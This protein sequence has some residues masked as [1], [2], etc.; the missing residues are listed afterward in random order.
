MHRIR[1]QF[2]R[3]LSPFGGGI[4]DVSLAPED[5]AAI[6]F[7]TKNAAP[8]LPLLEELRNLGHCFTF[9]YTINNYP[10]F[11]EP[12]VPQWGHT[13]EIVEQLSRRFSPAV[14]RWRYDTIVLSESLNWKWHK[15]NFRALC[16]SLAP[17]AT[18]CIFSFCDYYRKTVR[19]MERG[20][21][22]YWRPSEV[23][24][25]EMAEEMAD[26]AKQWG[27]SVSS[28]AHDFLVSE[29]V[30]KA[31]CIDPAVLSQIVNSPERLAAVK[32]LKKAPTRKDCGCAASR[33]VGAYDTCL[34]GCVY[35]YAN[36]DP[37]SARRNVALVTED[38]DCLDPRAA[39]LDCAGPP[40]VGRRS[41]R[42]GRDGEKSQIGA[43]NSCQGGKTPYDRYGSPGARSGD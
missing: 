11:V 15:R 36:A 19:N 35:C 33:D 34:H 42:K 30:A 27:I 14:F 2:V 20:A 16:R 24:C 43:D 1:R 29:K 38:S 3:V 17:F 8:L 13:K 7:W 23:Q 4:F 39:R 26:V 18:E 12:T 21:P 25:S 40:Q 37:E 31:R 10:A 28:C 9:L 32:A 41:G 6:V 22:G 5:V